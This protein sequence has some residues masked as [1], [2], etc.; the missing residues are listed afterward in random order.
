[1][2]LL[3]YLKTLKNFKIWECPTRIWMKIFYSYYEKAELIF[4]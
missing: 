1:M 4:N 2:R 3:D